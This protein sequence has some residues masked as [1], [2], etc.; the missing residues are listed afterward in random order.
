MKMRE[1]M[2]RALAGG[3]YANIRDNGFAQFGNEAEFIDKTWDL[4]LPRVDMV[5]DAMGP[6]DA[7]R[8]AGRDYTDNAVNGEVCG[9]IFTA[10]IAAAKE[11]K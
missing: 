1:K 8:L 6:T 9:C 11:E 5:L 7:M 4:W 2:A 3:A 10:M